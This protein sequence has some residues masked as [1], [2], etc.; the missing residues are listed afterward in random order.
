MLSLDFF[1][2]FFKVELHNTALFP[3]H[4]PHQHWHDGFFPGAL[5]K[6]EFFALFLQRQEEISCARKKKK[7]IILSF[8]CSRIA[9][10]NGSSIVTWLHS[11]L[12]W[13]GISWK[14][15][16]RIYSEI[17]AIIISRALLCHRFFSA[18]AARSASSL[19]VPLAAALISRFILKTFPR[20]N[21]HSSQGHFSGE[22]QNDPLSIT[23]I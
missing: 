17:L 19:S 10:T 3:E 8:S 13:I 18:V 20:L 7:H 22:H 12:Q 23:N 16:I 11:S 2:L 21:S 1:Y 15:K 9:N 4:V 5:I 14:K 6:A